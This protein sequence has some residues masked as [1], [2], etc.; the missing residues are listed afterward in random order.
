MLSLFLTFSFN[1]PYVSFISLYLSISRTFRV[2]NWRCAQHAVSDILPRVFSVSVHD[3]VKC[4]KNGENDQFPRFVE[5]TVITGLDSALLAKFC[6]KAP[7][8]SEPRLY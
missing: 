4:I 1:N 5:E 6:S 2:V 8:S 7:N 3:D